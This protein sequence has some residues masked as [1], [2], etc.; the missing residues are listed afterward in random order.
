MANICIVKGYISVYK[1]EN[2]DKLFGI[3]KTELEKNN[4]KLDF[5]GN[6]VFWDTSADQEGCKIFLNCC[7]NWAFDPLDMKKFVEWM[8]QFVPVEELECELKYEELGLEILGKY[9]LFD[10]RLED[11]FVRWIE[12]PAYP[13][14]NPED[15]EE[16]IHEEYLKKL[17]ELAESSESEIIHQFNTED[18]L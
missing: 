17:Y 13:E 16:K 4:A 7:M 11:Y 12:I 1:Q 9:K 8:L 15:A 3:I 2:A 6:S 14:I 5:G 10:G 18:V